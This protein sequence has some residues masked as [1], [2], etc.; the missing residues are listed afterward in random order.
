[1]RIR[2]ALLIVTMAGLVVTVQ[3]LSAQQSAPY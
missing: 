3:V 1:M 2:I